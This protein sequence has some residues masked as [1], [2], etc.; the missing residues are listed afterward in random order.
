[1]EDRTMT[2][3]LIRA[4]GSEQEIGKLSSSEIRALIG[5]ECLDCVSL[6]H[7]GAPLQVLVVDDAAFEV[8]MI[9][10]DD[11]HFELRPTRARKPINEAATRLYHANCR[12]G[13]VHQIAGDAIVCPDS[14]FE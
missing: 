4:D 10:H 12:A 6:R 1:M 8:E 2:R 9:K 11:G 5:A 3:R 14:D 13:T 7:L